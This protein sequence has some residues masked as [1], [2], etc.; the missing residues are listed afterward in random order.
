MSAFAELIDRHRLV[1]CVGTGGVGKTTVSAAIALA[2][3]RRGRR[4]MVLTIDPARALA[5]ALGL[6]ALAPGGEPV[7]PTALAAAGLTL[8]GALDAGMLDQKQAWDAF[9]RRHAPTPAAAAALLGNGFYQAMSTSFSGS[10]EYMAI[11]EM[12]RLAEAGHHDLIV[13]D[14]PPAAHALDF[15]RAPDRLAPLLERGVVAALSR[16]AAAAGALARFVLRKLEGA[17]GAGTVRDVAGFFV[18]LDALVDVVAERARRA[19]ALLHDGRA[20]FVLVAGPRALVLAETGT[21]A[22][23]MAA[24]SAPLSAVVLNRTQPR[25]SA[26]AEAIELALTAVDD[27]AARAWLT[28]A[29]GDA[30]AAVEAEDAAIE[31]FAAS[32]PTG[33]VVS[34]IPEAAGD[35]HTLAALAAM[36]DHL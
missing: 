24:V 28:S 9:V 11:E 29:W 18:A 32:L 6:D 33:V 35:V 17:L 8:R 31:R 5:R 22:A 2:A 3:A 7:P 4:A 21:L 27:P 19:A 14:T 30:Q 20:A 36:T 10:T 23:R 26:P 25:W 16:P 15:L 12:C 34:A 1:V 13:L